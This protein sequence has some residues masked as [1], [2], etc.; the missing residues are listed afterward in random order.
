MEKEEMELP[1][2]FTFLGF[3]KSSLKWS[4]SATTM[5]SLSLKSNLSI[6]PYHTGVELTQLYFF[7]GAFWEFDICEII[8]PTSTLDLKKLLSTLSSQV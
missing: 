7:K 6:Y 8:H 4:I 2:H 5:Y 3:Y 1:N